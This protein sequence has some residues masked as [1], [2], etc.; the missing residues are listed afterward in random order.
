MF[1]KLNTILSLTKHLQ[2]VIYLLEITD[3]LNNLRFV[4]KLL[5]FLIGMQ[6]FT[7]LKL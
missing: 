6:L 1:Y 7:N 3:T 5:W 2:I 4:I